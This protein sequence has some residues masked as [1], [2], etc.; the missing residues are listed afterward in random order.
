MTEAVIVGNA[1]LGVDRSAL[2]DGA[3][4]VV[5]FNVPR[6]WGAE[7]GTRFDAWVLA[8]GRAGLHFARQALFLDAPYRDLPRE[9]WFPRAVEVHRELLDAHAGGFAG[10]LAHDD[11]SARILRRNRLVQ[12]SLHFDA[13]FYRRCL[14]CLGEE[15]GLPDPTMIPSAGF[16]ATRHVLETMPGSRVTLIGFTFEGWPGHPWAQ[17]ARHIRRLAAAGRLTLLPG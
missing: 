8:N 17:E 9:I 14:A 6:T 7:S 13:D 4:F 3:D 11:V 15:G 10:S 16:L 5:R 12:P 2:V 1:A